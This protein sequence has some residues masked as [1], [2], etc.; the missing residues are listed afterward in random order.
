MNKVTDFYMYYS[1][2][3][4]QTILDCTCGIGTQTLGLAQLGYKIT[5]SVISTG[6]IARVKKEAEVRELDI[7]FFVAAFCNLSSIF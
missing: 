4:Q 7:V 6:E 5:G 3:K 2:T 1:I